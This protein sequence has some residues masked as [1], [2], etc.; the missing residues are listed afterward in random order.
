MKVLVTLARIPSLEV[1]YIVI[2]KHAINSQSFKNAPYGIADNYFAGVLLSEIIFQDGFHNTQV[3]YD[4]RNKETHQKRHFREHLETN[5]LGA[6]LEKG[7]EV[8]FSI[9][10]RESSHCYGLGAADFFSWSIFRRFEYDDPQFFY[11]IAHRLRRR[12]QWYIEK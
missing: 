6:A 5:V 2:N 11:L 9:D 1:S 12:R 10:G 4:I 3:I 7:V 8:E